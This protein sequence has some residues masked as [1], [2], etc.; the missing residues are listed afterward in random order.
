MVDGKRIRGLGV[1]VDGAQTHLRPLP[2]ELGAAEELSCCLLQPNPRR[3]SGLEP[4]EPAV[5]LFELHAVLLQLRRD[6]WTERRR[7]C[8]GIPIGAPSTLFTL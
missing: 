4:G 2:N 6:V 7:A 5:S 3:V 8:A 1:V